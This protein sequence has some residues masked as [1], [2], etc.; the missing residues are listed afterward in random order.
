MVGYRGG[1]EEGGY[2]QENDDTLDWLVVESAAQREGQS[3]EVYR[4]MGVES[5]D[6]FV[7]CFVGVEG[8]RGHG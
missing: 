5:E 1:S 4:C 3:R 6:L 8:C 7:R 2:L